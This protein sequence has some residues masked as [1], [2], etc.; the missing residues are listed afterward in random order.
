MAHEIERKFL[1][2]GDGWRAGEDGVLQKQGYITI[3]DHAVVRT[4]IEG[5][6]ATLTIKGAQQGLTRAEFEYEI[7]VADA[8]ALLELCPVVVEKTR[9]K[10][11]FGG[12]TWEIDVFH[13][14]NDGLITAEVELPSE[15]T[16]VELPDWVGEDVSMDVRYRVAALSKAPYATWRN[17]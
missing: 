17:G 7:P 1:V 16:E 3:A 9:H 10:R 5:T 12:Y 13:G 6:K 8:E 11:E 15:D 4:R 2:S 14:Q